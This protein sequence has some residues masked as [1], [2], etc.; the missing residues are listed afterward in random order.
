MDK[1]FKKLVEIPH[2]KLLHNFYG[3]LI[4]LVFSFFNPL[5]AFA[6][7]LIVAFAKEIYDEVIYKGYNISD[8]VATS[9]IP[10]LLFIKEYYVG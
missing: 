4:Y 1:I 7:V 10:L 8:I 6:I 2:D 9:F 5:L 3:T